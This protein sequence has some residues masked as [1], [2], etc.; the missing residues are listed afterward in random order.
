MK[1]PSSA[2]QQERKGEIFE[3]GASPLLSHFSGGALSAMCGVGCLCEGQRL[4]VCGI[5]SK[6]VVDGGSMDVKFY[7]YKEGGLTAENCEGGGGKVKKLLKSFC[8]NR[9]LYLVKGL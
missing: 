6:D 9:H 5:G 1:M 8:R 2:C 3:G 4:G 7:T